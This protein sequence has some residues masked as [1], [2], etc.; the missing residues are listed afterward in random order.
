MLN[1][2]F[3]NECENMRKRQ[4][5]GIASAKARGVQ[6]GRPTKKPPENFDQL[7]KEWECGKLRTK[8][9]MVQTGLTEST[10]YRRLRERKFRKKK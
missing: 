6:F 2:A 7:A 9:F 1:L 4:S 3:Q 8:D 5:E 10:L